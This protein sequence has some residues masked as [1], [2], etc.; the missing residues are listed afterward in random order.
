MGT[1]ILNRLVLVLAMFSCL[2]LVAGQD[3]KVSAPKPIDQLREL[4]AKGDAS[5][6]A[7]ARMAPGL[8]RPRDDS[9]SAR[10]LRRSAQGLANGAG[11]R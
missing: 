5:A 1:L 7:M 10:T 9:R 4:A 3:T 11:V 8:D 2:S 6:Q